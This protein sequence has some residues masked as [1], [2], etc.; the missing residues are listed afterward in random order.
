MF[1][2]NQGVFGEDEDGSGNKDDD[3]EEM[4]EDGYDVSTWYFCCDTMMFRTT[5]KGLESFRPLFIHH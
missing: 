3:V 5:G 4:S 1:P 2:H